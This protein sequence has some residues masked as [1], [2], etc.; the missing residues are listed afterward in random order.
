MTQSFIQQVSH[1]RFM[2]LGLSALV[3]VAMSGPALLM[4]EA[5]SADTGNAAPQKDGVSVVSSWSMPEGMDTLTGDHSNPFLS[6]EAYL[7]QG[8]APL[9]GYVVTVPAGTQVQATSQSPVSSETARAGD[10]FHVTLGSPLMS[11]GQ[12]ALPAGSM[13]EGQV[14]SVT[15]A[16]RGGRNGQLDIR[17]TSALTPSGQRVPLS[18]RLQTEDGTGVLKGGTGTSRAVKAG[19]RAAGGAAA[20]AILGTALGALSGGKVGRGAVYG[21]AVGGGLG[22]VYAG[23]KKGVEAVLSAGTPIQ[24]V[25]DTPVTTSPGHNGMGGVQQQAA[26]Y[27]G[28][29]QQQGNY[30]YSQSGN[31]PYSQPPSSNT[32]YYGQQQNYN[33]G[34]AYGSGYTQ[35]APQAPQ[36]PQAPQSTYTTQPTNPYGY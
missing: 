3:G 2:A 29:T 28:Y 21:T 9:Q 4:N 7:A 20:G 23:A 31:Q 30:S 27:G 18:A 25:L 17:F 32:G 14:I 35:P 33:Y 6:P 11:G 1:R 26:P 15:P 24:L 22:A 10:R 5:F 12:V 34:N 8:F 19:A 36:Q 16:G 13:V